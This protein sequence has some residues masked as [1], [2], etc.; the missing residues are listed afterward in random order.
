MV[1]VLAVAAKWKLPEWNIEYLSE[2]WLSI[3]I[4]AIVLI[5]SIWW[6]ARLTARATEDIDRAEVDRQMLTT[7]TELKTQGELTNEEFRSIKGRL[8]ERLADDEGIP[9]N[10][11]DASSSTEENDV[12]DADESTDSAESD[13]PEQDPDD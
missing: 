3:S 6:I 12:T 4:G 7:L 2:S 1:D 8:V 11:V 10:R 5:I 13:T 9:P